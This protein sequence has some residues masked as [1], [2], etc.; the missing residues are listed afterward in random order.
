MARWRGGD[1]H[2]GR[3]EG[4]SCERRRRHGGR[5]GKDE[6]ATTRMYVRDRTRA[7]CRAR[8]EREIV[9]AQQSNN[10]RLAVNHRARSGEGR[11]GLLGRGV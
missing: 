4:G 7:G 5:G 3:L 9:S 10:N 1:V 8:A 2:E 6:K 11:L